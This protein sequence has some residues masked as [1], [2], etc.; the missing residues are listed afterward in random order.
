MLNLL[1]NDWFLI[2][3]QF[4]PYTQSHTNLNIWKSFGKLTTHELIIYIFKHT[5]L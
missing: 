4:V 3:L 1:L 5:K 2:K